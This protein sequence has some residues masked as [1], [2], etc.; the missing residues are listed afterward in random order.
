[1]EFISIDGLRADGRR[2]LELRQI[3][4]EVGT[5]H[6]EGCDG[7]A[8]MAMGLSKARSPL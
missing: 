8:T 4:C 7:S 3:N 1:M 5:S 2:P 6:R